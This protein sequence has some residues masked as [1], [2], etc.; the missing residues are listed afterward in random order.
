MNFTKMKKNN[1]I[2]I[3]SLLLFSMIVKAQVGIGTSSPD[4]SSVIDV[5][6]VTK[7][8]LLP[9]MTSIQRNGIVPAALGLIIYN[10]DVSQIQVNI[11][12]I[13]LVP[14]W[15]GAVSS[16][17]HSG[18]GAG[19]VIGGGSSNTASGDGSTVA[20]GSS[21]VASGAYSAIGGGYS[22]T[23][24][25][26]NSAIAG[27]TTNV[28]YGEAASITGGTSNYAEGAKSHIGGGVSNY[29]L[30]A[31]SVISG[32]TSNQTIG[33]ADAILGGTGNF[34]NGPAA[35]V[36]GGTTNLATGSVAFVGGG[37]TNK[38][39]GVQSA[40]LGGT[41]NVASGLSSSIS[42]GTANNAIGANSTVSG[43][44]VNIA[45]GAQ[46]SISGGNANNAIGTNSSV[47]GGIGNTANSFGEWV[48]GLYGTIP[49]LQSASGFEPS[50]R[51]F[52]IGN[53]SLGTP[54]NA[55][56]ILKNGLA[57]L[58]SITNG[59]ITGDASGKAIVTKEF[60]DANYAKF[61]TIAPLGMNSIGV[62]GEIR[63]T[64]SFIYACV[65]SNNWIRIA[66]T[67]W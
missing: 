3:S 14:Q 20:G 63:M 48:G 11:S 58:P 1:F 22:N 36:V 17:V 57:T 27:G 18:T 45:T 25:G 28:T 60:T 15:T 55:L 4:V 31:A 34:A 29:T 62:L 44:N 56:T 23:A 7:G 51:L 54:S 49:S 47:S 40:I 21:N 46:S 10:T 43:G 32:G 5:S 38:A 65:A 41:A 66:V 2:I 42:G 52:N 6:S 12:T 9:R 39:T 33:A 59:L 30:G 61:S 35:A 67:P 26:A 24:S 8:M 19:S 50:D 37:L 16:L 53:G 13:P 64:S